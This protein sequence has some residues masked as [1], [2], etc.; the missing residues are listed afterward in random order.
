MYDIAQLI[1][2]FAS[3]VGISQPN[4]PGIPQVQAPLST[5]ISGLYSNNKNNLVQ[6]ENL[7]YAFPD[8]TPNNY[9]QW[10]SLTPYIIGN[11]ISDAGIIYNCIL[12]V[13][14]ATHPAADATHWAVYN[15]FQVALQQ[16]Y[17]QAITN[18]FSE[19]IRRKKLQH[20]AKPLMERHQLYMGGGQLS[21]RIINQGYA[22]GFEIKPVSAEGLWIFLEQ[23]GIQLTDINPAMTYYLYHSTVLNALNSWTFDITEI[24][25]FAWKKLLDSGTPPNYNAIMKYMSQNPSGVYYL[26]Y[27]QDDLGAA[28]AIGKEWDCTTAPCF[29]C[30][31]ANT[32]M[33]N[34]WSKYV[35]IRN[36]LVPA[37]YVNVDRTLFDTDRII[38]N[39]VSNWGLNLSLSA[40]CDFTDTILNNK[41]SYA[42]PLCYQLTYEFL[43]A[44]AKNSR[45]NPFNNQIQTQAR[46]DLDTKFPGSWIHQ[47]NDAIDSVV[48]DLSGFNKA[49][50]PC[51][52]E[53]KMKWNA[54]I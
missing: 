30:N 19:V 5:S 32:D 13:T 3:M 24:N 34:I 9:T 22:V 49:C 48:I 29:G 44:I 17:N 6:T 28:Q 53:K 14:S 36:V 50:I 8:C 40:R 16:K 1:S 47:Y 26:I 25:T 11:K 2:G 23:I 15:P 33:Y 7:L 18:F 45:A 46:A 38:Y 42:D 31:G 35:T 20:A 41:L 4:V 51:N 52:N 54:P 21:R 27:Y 37:A 10:V 43:D 12:G 39:T